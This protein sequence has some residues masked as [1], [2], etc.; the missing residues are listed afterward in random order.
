MPPKNTTPVQLQLASGADFE[1]VSGDGAEKGFLCIVEVYASWCG[2]TDAAKSTVSLL[3]MEFAGRKIK[4]YQ[5]CADGVPSL[6]KFNTTSRPHFLFFK[7]GGARARR[8]RASAR[9]G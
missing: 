2:P 8:T 7:D 3:H 6:E 5:A 9:P 1:Q 4:F